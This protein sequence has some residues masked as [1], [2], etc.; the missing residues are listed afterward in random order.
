[1]EDAF[2]NLSSGLEAPAL[3]HFLITPNDSEDLPTRPRAL[4]C[5]TAGFVAIRDVD[6]TDFIYAVTAGM[7]LPIRVQRVLETGTTATV[8]GWC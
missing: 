8:V 3:R 2:Q 1:M 6:G 4:Y 5:N 7:I